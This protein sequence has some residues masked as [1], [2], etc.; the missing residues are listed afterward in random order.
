MKLRVGITGVG[1]RGIGL[2][3][4]LAGME[5]ASIVALADLDA[6]RLDTA[7]QE[8]GVDRTFSLLSEMLDSVKLDA[9]LVLTP[10]QAHKPQAIRSLESGVHVLVEKP[11]AFTVEDTEQMAEAAEKAGK[12]LMV[13][14]NREYGLTRVKELF[15]S[16]PP[17]IVMADFV[18]PGPCYLGLIR[19]HLVDPLHYICGEPAEIVAHGEMFNEHQEGHIL[20]SIRFKGG[21]LG[22]LTS[23]FGSGGTSE[24]FTAYGGGYTV[25][26]ERTSQPTITILKGRDEVE[27]FGPLNTTQLD[28]RHFLDC[29]KDDRE[30]LTSGRQAVSI[31][32]F[33]HQVMEAAGIDM[34]PVPDDGRGWGLWCTCG[35]RVIP[36]TEACPQCGREWAGWSL[37]IEAVQQT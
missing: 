14:W 13:A 25:F 33:M 22:Q 11:P 19:N 12:H 7:A 20:A 30:P 24:R 23:S 32:R 29:I 6:R 31:V 15:A 37:P 34:P 16:E 9:V 26:V 1:H 36:N 8:L 21:T 3:R 17:E 18:R 10:D 2:A 4:E 35:G 28:V 5:D 27:S